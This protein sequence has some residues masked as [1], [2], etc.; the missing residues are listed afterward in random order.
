MIYFI[1][2]EMIFSFI[3]LKMETILL[4]FSRCILEWAGE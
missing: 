1:Y 2:T 4:F 3:F